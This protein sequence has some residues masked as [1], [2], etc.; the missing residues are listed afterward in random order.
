MSPPPASHSSPSAGDVDAA[1][2]LQGLPGS[3]LQHMPQ[4]NLP[5][6]CLPPWVAQRRHLAIRRI[7]IV[8]PIIVH[9]ERAYR[10]RDG[11]VRVHS[12]RICLRGEAQSPVRE[13]SWED[14]QLVAIR[15]QEQD[16]LPIVHDG[17]AIVLEVEDEGRCIFRTFSALKNAYNTS[18]SPP[19]TSAAPYDLSFSL[20]AMEVEQARILAPFTSQPALLHGLAR[21]PR[22]PLGAQAGDTVMHTPCT[23]DGSRSSVRT[24]S[25]NV[26][27]LSLNRTMME[28]TPPTRAPSPPR[29][30]AMLMHAGPTS[31]QLRARD[32]SNG[33]HPKPEEHSLQARPAASHTSVPFPAVHLQLHLH[34]LLARAHK[35]PIVPSAT[36]SPTES[37]RLRLQCRK[38]PATPRMS[39]TVPQGTRTPTFSDLPVG[40]PVAGTRASTFSWTGKRPPSCSKHDSAQGFAAQLAHMHIVKS[41]HKSFEGTTAHARLSSLVYSG[42]T[43]RRLHA[44]QKGS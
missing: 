21:A 12:R 38:M 15:V 4:D 20:T 31:S 33:Y 17:K 32:S 41:S 34:P 28:R 18:T 24:T 7:G 16:P 35:C 37:A 22:A 23:D 42:G 27:I 2:P 14:I 10:R 25:F 3:P 40:R 8:V 5:K 29:P 13:M 26:S 44:P 6:S 36:H 39:T 30:T 11:P 43:G 1:S 19:P 9:P